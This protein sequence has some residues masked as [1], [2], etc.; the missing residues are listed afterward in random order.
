MHVAPM[1]ALLAVVALSWRWEWLGGIVFVG[2]ALAYAYFARAHPSWV[3]AI[4]APLFIVGVLFFWSWRHHG[5]L[6]AH[7]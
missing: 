5:R 3:L 6:H 7:A 1:L 2:L 4:A